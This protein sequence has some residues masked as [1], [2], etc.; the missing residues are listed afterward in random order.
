MQRNFHRSA[1]AL[2]RQIDIIS[3]CDG[4]KAASARRRENRDS[5]DVSYDIAALENSIR[6][7]AAHDAEHHRLGTKLEIPLRVSGARADRAITLKVF[8]PEIV[9]GGRPRSAWSNAGNLRIDSGARNQR[10]HDDC[11]RQDQS[12][13]LSH[14]HI[15]LS[16]TTVSVC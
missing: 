9:R 3:W 2:D 16:A 4:C 6:R 5:V 1:A 13:K 12:G 14:S 11:T 7:P 15:S 8:D 10:R